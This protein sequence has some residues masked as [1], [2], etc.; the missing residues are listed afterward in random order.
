MPHAQQSRPDL[1]VVGGGI[2]GL[3]TAARAAQDGL[4]AIVLERSPDDRYVCNS[5]MT[6]GVFHCALTSIT[7]PPEELRRKIDEA[8]SGQADPEQA[9]AVASDALRAVRWLQQ[10][11]LRFVRG[12]EP[13]HD[14]TLAPPTINPLN[15]GWEGRGGDVLLRT[16]E[17]ALGR[18]GGAVQ[19]GMRARSLLMREQRCVGVQGEDAQGRPFQIEADAVVI[20]DGGFQTQPELL[21]AAITPA[22]GKVFQ[23][24]A[25][26][27]M[28]DG[29][30]MVREAGG[31]ISDLRGFYGHILSADAFHNDR[32]WPHLWLDFVAAAGLL[33]DRAGRRFTDE[34]RGGVSMANAIAAQPDPL[35]TFAIADQA[36][37]E[38]RGTFNMQAPNPRLEEFGG[39][40]FHAATLSELAAKA[41]IDA[42]ALQA[43]VSA[44][45]DALQAGAAEGL[46]PPRSK[47][48]FQPYPLVKPPFHA[49]PACAGVT[50][51]MGGILIDGHSRV[52]DEQRRPIGGLYAAGAATGGLEGGPHTGYVGGLIKSSVAGLRAAE[53]IAASQ[54]GG[55]K[56]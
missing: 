31:A 44:Y 41:G 24:N 29:L 1:V 7:T 51:T 33:V 39:T 32:L 40:A 53:S 30:K 22:P 42:D 48:K 36:I 16:L 12:S 4:R 27:G 14:F 18:A 38:Q 8:T 26:T 52:L 34:G 43:T 54:R 2:A 13:Y 20:A 46:Q 49:F 55:A 50:Y 6:A 56:P 9:D 23:R 45:N 11:G 10:Q 28:G 21:Q 19:R 15:R 37:W 3:V 5:R 25:R 47:H 35:G 17:A